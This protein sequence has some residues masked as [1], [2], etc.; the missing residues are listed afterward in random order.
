[1]MIGLGRFGPGPELRA[2]LETD[3]VGERS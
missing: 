2:F 1:M 3:L